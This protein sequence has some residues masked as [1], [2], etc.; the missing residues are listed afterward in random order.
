MDVSSFQKKKKIGKTKI[1]PNKKRV[2]ALKLSEQFSHL[3]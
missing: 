3:P 2:L 1:S